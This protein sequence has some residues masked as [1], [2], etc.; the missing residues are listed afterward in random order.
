[1]RKKIIPFSLFFISIILG[2]LLFGHF[3]TPQFARSDD[4][5]GKLRDQEAAIEILT[6]EQSNLKEQITALRTEIDTLSAN[7]SFLSDQQKLDSLNS[8]IGLT[9]L[10]GNGIIIKL[11][12]S[13]SDL[14]PESSVV[15]SA[16]LRDLVQRLWSADARAISINNQRI[17]ALTPITA[18]G[19]SILINDTRINS[20]FEIQ[21]LQGES[22][23]A[24]ELNFDLYLPEIAQRINTGEYQLTLSNSE[25]ITIPVFDGRTPTDHLTLHHD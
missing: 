10:S 5:L 22:N 21:V 1:M 4:E 24:Q 13:Y 23:L 2:F 25:S 6:S 18:V 12:P 17:V 3:N 9:E 19:S 20:P 14:T 11:A 8:Q 15:Y 7:K 16:D